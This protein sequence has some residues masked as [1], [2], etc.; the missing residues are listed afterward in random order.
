[1]TKLTYFLLLACAIFFAACEKEEA[2]EEDKT[3]RQFIGA[4]QQVS[5]EESIDEGD[6]I[7]KTDYCDEHEIVVINGD[8]DHSLHL[9]SDEPSLCGDQTYYGRWDI[10]DKGTRMTWNLDGIPEPIRKHVISIDGSQMI[11]IHDVNIATPTRIR[12]IYNKQ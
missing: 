6:W 9:Y 2:D 10:M 5:V 12:I 1:M 11:T 8:S 3:E 4:W 7:N